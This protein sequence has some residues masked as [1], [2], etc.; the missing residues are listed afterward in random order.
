QFDYKIEAGNSGM[1]YR[2]KVIDEEKFIVGGYQADIEAGPTYTGINYE[3]RGR[4]I[5][6]ER[7]QRVTIADDGSKSVEN[8][9]ERD[10][11]A[12]KID[13][14]TWNHYRIVA[15]GN[16]LSHYINDQ[17]MSEVIDNQEDKAAKSG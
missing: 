10:V 14:A 7:G 15:N 11:L 6:A 12:K 9:G 3:E 1:Q 16:T 17:L 2:S 4:G 13:A 8:F 5:L